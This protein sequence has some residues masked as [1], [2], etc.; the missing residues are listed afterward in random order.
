[1]PIVGMLD[2]LGDARGE[3]LGQGLEHDGEG[4]RL[5]DGTRVRLERRPFGAEPATRLEAADRVDGLRGEP[6]MAHH[7]NA[8]LG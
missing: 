1:M 7:R 2:L 8:A 6:D 5:G 4:A 3:K